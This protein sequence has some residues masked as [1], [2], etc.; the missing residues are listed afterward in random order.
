MIRSRFLRGLVAAALSA[1]AVAAYADQPITITILHTNDMHARVEPTKIKGKLYGGYARLATLIE[2]YKKSDP[3]PVLLNAGDTFQGTMYFNVYEGLADLAFMN[4]VGF[5]AMSA[6]NHE[7]DRGPATFATFIKAAKFP[8]L[9]ANIDV[10]NDKYLDGLIKPSAVINV[11]GTKIGV[12][13]AV[14]EDLP[15]ISSPGDNVKMLNLMESVQREANRLVA[16][17]IDKIFLLTHV[18]YE[19][20]LRLAAQIKGIDVVVGGHSHSPLGTPK[21]DGFPEAR[22]PYPTEVKGAE[23]QKVLVVQGWEWGKVLGRIRV[24]FDRAGKVESYFADLP[25]VVDE[26]VPEDSVMKSMIAAFQKP[27]ASTI[28]QVIG[29]AAASIPT[30][31]SGS[32]IRNSPMGGLI[33]DAMMASLS[34]HGAVV[35][36]INGGGVR[37]AIEQGPITYGAAI[38]V[39]P[40]GNTLTVLEVSGTELVAAMEQSVEGYPERTGGVLYPSKGTS[41]MIDLTKPAGRRISNVVIAGQ[42]LAPNK[43]YKIGLNSFTASGGDSLT[44]FKEAKGTRVDTGNLDIDAFVD[45]IK[46]HSPL[47]VEQEQRLKVTNPPIWLLMALHPEYVYMSGSVV[48]TESKVA[49]FSLR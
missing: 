7:F 21:I 12:I 16:S 18:G 4:Y 33:A 8:V 44:I 36:F 47:K 42:S 43:T 3:N 2:K 5:Q 29:E 10:S 27:I 25:I 38:G 30:Y 39:Q 28:N 46:A 22:G 45:Y 23:G 1:L 41:Y 37:A 24:R 9:A 32:G 13:G 40:F 49:A 26:S 48:A 11:G 17:G 15:G 19:V 34:K 6:G 31:E 20:D 14:P 35:S